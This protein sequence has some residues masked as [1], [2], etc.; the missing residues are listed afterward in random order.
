MKA[1]A[2]NCS[3]RVNQ[4]QALKQNITISIRTAA[5]PDVFPVSAAKEHRMKGSVSSMTV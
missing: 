3:P 5:L 2:I 4:R 1:I